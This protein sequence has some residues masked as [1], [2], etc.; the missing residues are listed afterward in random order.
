MRVKQIMTPDPAS[1]TPDATVQ[2]AAA[3]MREKMA[4]LQEAAQAENWTKVNEIGDALV[5]AAPNQANSWG[6]KLFA[7]KQS[8]APA[9]KVKKILDDA[10]KSLI[11]A[12]RQ[13]AQ[14]ST[15]WS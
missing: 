1:C 10:L 2:Q 13:L 8:A 3:L 15:T 12:P 5:A 7:A 14:L 6:I 4:Q 11:S 9:E